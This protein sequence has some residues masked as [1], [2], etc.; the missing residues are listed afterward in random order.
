MSCDISGTF[1]DYLKNISYSSFKGI[2]NYSLVMTKIFKL[3]S[4]KKKVFGGN[5]TSITTSF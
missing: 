5:K 3:L 2:T 4:L 1:Y